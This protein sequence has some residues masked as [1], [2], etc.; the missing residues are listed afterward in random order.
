MAVRCR[1]FGHRWANQPQL[2][3]ICVTDW[4]WRC[5]TKRWIHLSG[6]YEHTCGGPLP[7]KRGER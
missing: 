2:E 4:C 3:H 1:W 7:G 6:P 5:W